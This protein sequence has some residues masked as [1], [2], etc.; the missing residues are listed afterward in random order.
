MP[1]T[2]QRSLNL[3]ADRSAGQF[4]WQPSRISS[5]SSWAGWKPALA[6]SW[7]GW[8]RAECP[9]SGALCLGQGDGR[10]R[11]EGPA[12]ALNG[13]PEGMDGTA[14]EDVLKNEELTA[15]ITDI[16]GHYTYEDPAVK[17]EMARMLE[18]L[19]K[20]GVD[21]EGYVRYNLKRAIAP[22]TRVLPG[23]VRHHLQADRR[24]EKRT[25]ENGPSWRC[26]IVSI[27]HYRDQ[28]CDELREEW[29][30]V[31]ILRL[32]QRDRARRTHQPKS[33]K[34]FVSGQPL[35]SLAGCGLLGA[36][37]ISAGNCAAVS[38]SSRAAAEKHR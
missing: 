30:P 21:G 19:A 36:D 31:R 22:S 17:A 8:R 37:A 33:G 15:Q 18:N 3:P 6:W 9:G 28:Q 27:I 32:P 20:V 16:C 34:R 29:V 1:F 11:R 5:R 38:A 25:I 7:P 26:V 12:L 24:S 2:V 14:V 35:R 23:A 13:M 10:A 4:R